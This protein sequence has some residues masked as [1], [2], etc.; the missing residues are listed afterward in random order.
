MGHKLSLP[1]RGI[2]IA[3]LHR[4]VEWCFVR[5]LLGQSKLV[6]LDT[7]RSNWTL[8]ETPAPLVFCT[9]FLF[10]SDFMLGAFLKPDFLQLGLSR[11]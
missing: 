4:N 11:C 7:P 2:R 9:V 8:P 10:E 3:M 5:I 6:S 1:G